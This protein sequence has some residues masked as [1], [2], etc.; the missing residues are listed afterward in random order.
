MRHRIALPA[1]LGDHFS[2]KKAST[3][4][5]GR[6]RADAADLER[7]FHGVRSISAPDTFRAHVDCYVP[8]LRPGQRFVGRTAARIWELPH[9]TP[10]C[11]DEPLQIAVPQDQSPPRTSGVEGRRL[12]TER[13]QTWMLGD[14][15]VVDPIAAVLSSAGELTETEIVILLDALISDSSNYPGRDNVRWPRVT[16]DVVVERVAL[17]DRFAGS[18]RVKRAIPRMRPG[19]ESPKETETRLLLVDGG[20]PEPDVQYVVRKEGRFVARVDLAYPRWRIAIEYEG[21]GHRRDRSQWRRDIA[22]QRA[23][24]DLGWIVIRLTQDDLDDP[25]AFVA[26]VRRAVVRRGSLAQATR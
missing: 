9:P 8:R 11:T 1:E 14:V 25:R 17:W 10:W 23:L 12:R 3:L 19:V 22:R 13:A 16:G 26:R 2:V 7:P 20:L 18:S 21:D 6:A 24:E 4:G 5:L 15:P